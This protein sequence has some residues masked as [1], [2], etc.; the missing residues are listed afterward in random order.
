MELPAEPLYNAK[1]YD[2]F[3]TLYQLIVIELTLQSD[4]TMRLAFTDLP[5]VLPNH[6][7]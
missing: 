4:L 6:L 1:K 7:P 2:I 5:S 3:A